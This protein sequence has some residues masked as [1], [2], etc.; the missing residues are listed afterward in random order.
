MPQV[1]QDRKAEKPSSAASATGYPGEKKSR[2]RLAFLDMLL[3]HAEAEKL[4]DDDVQ[5]EVDTFM[6]AV[7]KLIHTLQ[8]VG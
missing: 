5:E 4:T 6:F 8:T 3:E 1:I 7:C 2:R